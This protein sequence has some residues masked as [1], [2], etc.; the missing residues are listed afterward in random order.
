[1]N[2]SQLRVPGSWVFLGRFLLACPMET[3]LLCRKEIFISLEKAEFK[4]LFG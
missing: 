4:S 3:V 2:V 1:M